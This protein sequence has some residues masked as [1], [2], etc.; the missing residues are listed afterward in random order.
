MH[1]QNKKGRTLKV[2]VE[3]I[4][5]SKRL[6]LALHL[7]DVDKSFLKA[8]FIELGMESQNVAKNS[9]IKAVCCA[10]G[11]DKY[12]LKPYLA[13]IDSFTTYNMYFN[14]LCEIGRQYYMK[15]P[16]F[17]INDPVEKMKILKEIETKVNRKG[18]S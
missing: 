7:A 13:S 4:F 3:D 8:I 5:Q 15:D 12:E 16:Q 6:E 2:T 17:K 14:Q 11:L 1:K 9:I 18:D 10:E